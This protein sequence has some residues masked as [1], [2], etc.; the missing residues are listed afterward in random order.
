MMAQVYPREACFSRKEAIQAVQAG[1]ARPLREMRAVAEKA[2][3]GEMVDADM[4]N[5][6]GVLTYVL[7]VLTGSGKVSYVTLDATKGSI[8]GVR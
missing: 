5:Q 2:A 4:C 8:L 1:R 6:N 3:G 7:T